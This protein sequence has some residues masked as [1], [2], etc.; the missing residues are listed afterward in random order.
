M[1]SLRSLN[2]SVTPPKIGLPTKTFFIQSTTTAH[3]N[4][5]CCCLWT[6]PV[7]VTRVTFEMWGAGGDGSGGFCC[8]SSAVP[9]VAG[10]YSI[11]QIDAVAG[12]QY[13][14]CAASSGCCTYCYDVGNTGSP[15]YVFGIT[16]NA[17]IACAPGGQGGDNSPTRYG[18]ADGY[19]CC[20]GRLSA[21]G[22][23]DITF[24]GA[25]GAAF[26]NQYC[27][28]NQYYLTGSGPFGS[29]GRTSPDRC[30]IWACNG[31]SIMKSMAAFPAG[32]GADPQVC[33]GGMCYGQFGQGGMIKVTYS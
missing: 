16:E 27:H 31:C 6:V 19:T 23:G 5:G 14:L 25:G 7:N 30:S 11:K 10:S 8:E 3:Q 20:Y 24:P 21:C 4:G 33:G 15:S 32:P 12:R 28:S 22:I 26:R 17:V 1:P 13:R 18:S 9:A 2:S 29:G